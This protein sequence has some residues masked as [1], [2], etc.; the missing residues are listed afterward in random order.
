LRPRTADALDQQHNVRIP[1][2]AGIVSGAASILGLTGNLLSLRSLPSELSYLVFRRAVGLIG[3][4]FGIRW[5]SNL[6]ARAGPRTTDSWREIAVRLTCRIAQQHTAQRMQI[7]D[8]IRAVARTI[9][10]SL[11]RSRPGP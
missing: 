1:W 5:F 2:F 6:T 3:S 8:G 4:Q 10:V 11:L 7:T 9:Q